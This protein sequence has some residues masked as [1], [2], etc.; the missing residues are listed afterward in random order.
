MNHID[1]RSILK[2]EAGR[3]VT[4]LK[5]RNTIVIDKEI[6]S[7]KQLLKIS[8]DENSRHIYCNNNAF[9]NITRFTWDFLHTHE[10]IH[11]YGGFNLDS[12]R[13]PF[14]FNELSKLKVSKKKKI[15]QALYVPSKPRNGEHRSFYRWRQKKVKKNQWIRDEILVR[16]DLTSKMRFKVALSNSSS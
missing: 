11:I 1:N 7:Q 13:L 5:I 12:S 4:C 9:S 6:A 3:L 10:H 15:K 14:I 8:L 16:F 2:H